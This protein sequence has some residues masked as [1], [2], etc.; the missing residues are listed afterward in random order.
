M[1]RLTSDSIGR[2]ATYF[3]QPFPFSKYDQ[4]LLPGFAYG[5]MEHAGA[6]FLREDAIVFRTTPTVSDKANRASLVL[7]ELTHQWF[8]DLVTMKWFDDLWLKE[9]FANY[10]ASHAM[11]GLRT[12][13]W[14]G[15][16]E[17]VNVWKRFYQVHKPLAY[18]ID[19]TQGTTPIFQEVS[20][21]AD[22]KSAYGAIVYQK[23]PTLLRALAFKIGEEKFRDGVR[24]FLKE[25]VY[26]N[27]EWA[28]LISAFER[29]SGQ[30]LN[31]WALAWITQRGMPQV[32]VDWKCNERGTIDRLTLRQSDVLGHNSRWP[33]KTRVLL[34]YDHTTSTTLD[35]EFE[36]ESVSVTEAEGRQCPA[37]IFGNDEDYAYGRFL[38]DDRSQAA[39]VETLAGPAP[40]PFLRTMLWG[41]LWDAVRE[42]RMRPADYIAVALVELGG[43]TDELAVQTLLS[44]VTVTFQRYLS[45]SEREALAPKIEALC[46]EKMVGPGDLGRRISYFRAFRSIAST[47]LGRRRLKEILA[48]RLVLN[49]IELKPLDRWQI[50]RALLG[51]SD[52]DAERLLSEERKR[53][54]TNE[55]KKQAYLSEAARRDQKTKQRYFADYLKNR[56]V[57]EDWIEGSLAG[58]NFWSQ[59][60]LTLPFLRAS[61][62]ALPQIK[63]ERKIFFVLAWLNAFIGARRACCTRDRSVVP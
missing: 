19:S 21:L 41:A 61:L 58:F 46:F 25:H 53:D 3:D 14:P 28:D 43:Q 30:P 13:E 29:T 51:T 18:A 6:T 24:L 12:P 17:A 32:D 27:A 50:V 60:E 33:I 20:N 2:L 52:P 62:D 55:G 11:V 57:P 35:V 16:S 45:S 48:G 63:G 15:A 8:G 39:F 5:G 54:E 49:E 4:V 10:M 44:R 37:Y 40:A 1:L 56:T 59:P 38:L 7:H 9:G 47:E 22:A 36:S 31:E 42:A 34:W 26:A 23:A